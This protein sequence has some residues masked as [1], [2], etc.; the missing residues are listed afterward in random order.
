MNKTTTLVIKMVLGAVG[1]VATIASQAIGEGKNN[2]T[3][4]N[5]Q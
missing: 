1:A 5:K 2:K 4:D 3:E